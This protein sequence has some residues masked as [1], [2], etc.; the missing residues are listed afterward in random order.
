MLVHCVCV[1]QDSA[2]REV[3][4]SEILMSGDLMNAN[5]A[6]DEN[7]ETEGDEESSA[8]AKAHA[9]VFQEYKPLKV[10][11]GKQHQAAIVESAAMA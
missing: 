11:Y 1:L 8:V 4:E 9:L 10:T 5:A 2:L 3:L 6:D 7:G